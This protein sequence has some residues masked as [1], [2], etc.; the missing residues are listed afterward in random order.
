MRHVLP[1]RIFLNAV[2]ERRR[3]PGEVDNGNPVRAPLPLGVRVRLSD[4]SLHAAL[5]PIPLLV[6]RFGFHPPEH[7][8]APE[9]R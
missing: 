5:E 4:T 6:R 7:Y 8:R 1:T 2:V 3:T 9:G